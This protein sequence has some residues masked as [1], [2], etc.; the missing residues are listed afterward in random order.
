MENVSYNSGLS[1]GH[2]GKFGALKVCDLKLDF[3]FWS[4]KFSPV[5]IFNLLDEQDI[6]C[7]LA[8]TGFLY[9]M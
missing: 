8:E 7:L 1:V 6:I 4:F 9:G 2:Q 3:Q 5:L